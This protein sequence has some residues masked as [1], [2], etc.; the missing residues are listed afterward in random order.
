[1]AS[2]QRVLSLVRLVRQ[3]LRRRALVQGVALTL[4]TL[5]FFV[6]LYLVVYL[7]TEIELTYLLAGAA[8]AGV[9][10]LYV[11]VRYLVQPLLLK[12]DDRQVALFIEEKIPGLEDRLNSAVE[13]NSKMADAETGS[14][15][16]RLVDD[17]V[18]QVRSIPITTVVDRKKERIM[19]VAAGAGALLFL[20][21]GYYASD[22]ILSAFSGVK[23]TLAAVE[24]QPPMTVA[25]GNVEIERGATQ[26]VIVELRDPTEEEVF[27]TFRTPG[28][29]WQKAAMRKGIGQPVY[30][31]EF[32]GVQEPLEYFVQHDELQS[33]IF[34]VSLYAFPEIERIDLRYTYPAY[35]G[36]PPR[37]EED[38]GDIRGLKGARVGVSVTATGDLED[39]ALVMES[40]RRVPLQS[41]GDGVYRAEIA[42]EAEDLYHVELRDRAGK[43]NKFPDDYLIVPEED[44]RPRITITDPQQDVRV[45][46]IEEVVVAAKVEDDYGVKDLRLRFSVNGEDEETVVL[47]PADQARAAEV[48]GDYVFFLEDYELEPGDVISY[49]VEAEDFFAGRDAE[50]SDMY[51]I[52]VAPFD[53]RFTQ[54]NNA[55]GGGGGGGGQSRTVISQQEIIAATWKLH[56]SRNEGTPEAFQEAVRG[57][58]QAQA[59]LKESIEERIGSTAFSLELR[60]SEDSQK[61]VEYLRGA[62]DEMAGA[63][64]V[65]ET[66]K[67][68]E[69]LAPERR[70]LNFL[71]RADALN[72]D[73][74]VALNRNQQG[75]GGG[76]GGSMEDRMTELMDLELDISRDK[77][78]MQQQSPQPGGGGGEQQMDD[79]MQRIKELARKQQRL[80]N[81]RQQSLQGEDE[82]RFIERLKRDQDEIREQAEELAQQMEQMSRGEENVSREMQQGLQRAIDNMR[83]A[84]RSLRNGDD[85]RAAAQQQQALNELDQLQ[86]DMRMAGAD[87][88]RELLDEFARDFE[89]M[90]AQEERLGS[91]IASA[92]EKAQETGRIDQEEL[93][94]LRENRESMRNNL[95]R[96]KRQAESLEAGIRE[97]D[98]EA[99]TTLR[100]MMQQMRRDDLEK[101]M[102]DS[103]SALERGWIDFAERIQDSIDESLR[104]L[105]TQA[106]ELQENLPQTDEDQLR[107]ALA[108]LQDIRERME[109]A[110][111][112]AGQ[113]GQPSQS[114]QSQ[115]PQQSQQQGQQP[116]Q[117]SQGQQSQN[118]QGQQGQQ[119][120]QSE[121]QP[122]QQGGARGQAARMQQQARQAQQTL[123]R[124]QEQL[125]G[126]QEGDGEMQRSLQRAQQSL[127]R[128]ADASFTGILIDEESAKDFFNENV[129]DP[130]SDLEMLLSRQLDTIEMEK[131][132][133]G[134]RNADVPDEYR[135]AVDRYYESL[136]KSRNE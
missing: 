58:V 62:V 122:G 98:P 23:Y 54:A 32:V 88:K 17:A 121:G 19:A 64:E 52:E 80:A 81:Q 43:Q 79:A 133:Y 59:S 83:E 125:G 69:A 45:N 68:E 108:D 47:M 2:N 15:L 21:Y 77:Y 60:D 29:E 85:Q 78:E 10:V 22:A 90:R 34:T 49:Y 93:E 84:E 126:E 9:A 7:N 127:R 67:L 111:E 8:L 33:D 57:L 75:G 16:D 4:L 30:L 65:L 100:N 112:R 72:R 27:I 118:P 136:S 56:R 89:E 25:P 130:L 107:R 82:K 51:F 128:V 13:V 35:T 106:R 135:D 76:G 26:E 14:L 63:I 109:E 105:T 1:M 124:L 66:A 46:A 18:Q 61:I 102:D 91:D 116:G 113:Q 40:G 132:L 48:T 41:A 37:V 11:A 44:E 6:V 70:A 42:L 129:Y 104:G 101:N 71:L 123:E 36:L 39:A 31:H 119:G 131:K 5:L 117:D 50:A 115:N 120:Q 38:R 114:Q 74:Q 96:M 110:Q 28:G 12:M 134:S 103:Q 24:D 95:D 73:R 55:G 20:V 99:A 53:Q 94:N 3:R 97:E 87:N 92:F 86:Q